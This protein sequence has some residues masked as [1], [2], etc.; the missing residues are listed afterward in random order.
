M[1]ALV[2][3]DR[4]VLSR[5]Y[6]FST[7]KLNRVKRKTQQNESAKTLAWAVLKLKHKA[8]VIFYLLFINESQNVFQLLTACTRCRCQSG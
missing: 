8:G 7:S 5:L 2:S 4:I 1:K 3:H 6:N